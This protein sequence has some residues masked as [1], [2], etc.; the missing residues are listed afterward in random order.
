MAQ[1]LW[2]RSH[3]LTNTFTLRE[4]GRIQRRADRLSVNII[5]IVAGSGH[6]HT[7]NALIYLGALSTQLHYLG[8][9]NCSHYI[10]LI[11]RH[12]GFPLKCIEFELTIAHISS[13]E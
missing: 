11:I 12:C 8:A 13:G 2:T 5:I 7:H 9:L 4:R 6:T 1:T 10:S 3:K